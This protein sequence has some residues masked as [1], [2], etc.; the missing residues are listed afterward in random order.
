[1][2]FNS[3]DGSEQ[4]SRLPRPRTLDF[5]QRRE[6]ALVAAL[7][8][9]HL[10]CSRPED[11]L[12]RSIIETLTDANLWHPEDWDGEITWAVQARIKALREAGGPE[13]VVVLISPSFE[14][15]RS[16]LADLGFPGVGAGSLTPL[17]VAPADRLAELLDRRLGANVG[18]IVMGVRLTDPEAIRGVLVL[19]ETVEIHAVAPHAPGD[20]LSSLCI[21][22]LAGK[23][24]HVSNDGGGTWKSSDLNVSD[25]LVQSGPALRD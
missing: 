25:A 7:S 24:L 12:G 14:K 23:R 1:M 4:E 18:A 16:L 20:A 19:P 13:P 9:Q 11:Y 6:R 2:A 5:A 3:R 22:D 21:L 15:G 10:P 17:V 8:G